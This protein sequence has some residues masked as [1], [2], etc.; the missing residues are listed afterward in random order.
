MINEFKVR[1]M[2]SRTLTRKRILQGVHVTMYRPSVTAWRTS[3]IKP[4]TLLR[5]SFFLNKTK[6]HTKTVSVSYGRKAIRTR[7]WELW[8]RGRAFSV[9]SSGDGVSSLESEHFFRWHCPSNVP[10]FSA[11][12]PDEAFWKTWWRL[13]R[14]NWRRAGIV[15]WFPFSGL[16]D[17]NLDLIIVNDLSRKLFSDVGIVYYKNIPNGKLVKGSRPI[18]V[19]KLV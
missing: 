4:R 2:L 17:N 10:L 8:L 6:K 16:L 15:F 1:D 12:S 18:L 19:S 3:A 11:V 14:C 5:R 9:G 13:M 7:R